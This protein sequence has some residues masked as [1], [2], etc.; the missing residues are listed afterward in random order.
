MKKLHT[1]PTALLFVVILFI[2]SCE[3]NDCTEC[4]DEASAIIRVYPSQDTNSVY[5]PFSGVLQENVYYY[6]YL[7]GTPERVQF[8][9]GLP[10]N[11]ICTNEHLNIS[12]HVNTTNTTSD[13]PI[14]IF[15]EI[16]WSVFSDDIQ[17]VDDIML[18]DHSYNG[19]INNVGLKQA[20]PEGA[21]EA[22]MYVTVEFE[23]LGSLALDKAYFQEHF[24]LFDASYSYKKF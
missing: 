19:Q 23:S 20:F 2:T 4:C 9:V 15:G 7:G 24:F 5:Q 12:F 16:Y 3:K 1:L 8:F 14:K 6:F 10:K 18:P 11:D 21:A 17:L 13:R 22:D